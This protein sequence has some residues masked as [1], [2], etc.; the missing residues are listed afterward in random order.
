MNNSRCKISVLFSRPN[1]KDTHPA[2]LRDVIAAE[3]AAKDC[4]MAR[5]NDTT[6]NETAN[7]KIMM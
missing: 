2:T 7:S 1:Y 6:A 5:A 3:I 4:K